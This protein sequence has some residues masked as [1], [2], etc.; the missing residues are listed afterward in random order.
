MLAIAMRKH[1]A[2]K[3]VRLGV[4]QL[5]RTIWLEAEQQTVDQKPRPFF[6]NRAAIAHEIKAA[7]KQF[8]RHDRQQRIKNHHH[9]PQRK[10]IKRKR[11]N[12]PAA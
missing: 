5:L 12:F 10:T 2:G 6:G 4:T 3:G 1:D 11:I 8:L 9:I 7:E